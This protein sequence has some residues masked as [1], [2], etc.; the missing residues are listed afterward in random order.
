MKIL[1]QQR[2]LTLQL[3]KNGASLVGFGDVSVTKSEITDRFPVAVAL[4][5]KFDDTIV[6]NLHNDEAAFHKHQV[7]VRAF[8]E[9]L[10]GIATGML[11][12]WGYWYEIAP[13]KVINSNEELSRFQGFPYKTAATCAG[14]GWIGKSDLLVTPEHGPRVRLA[15][16]LTD[17]PFKTAEPVTE[18]RCGSCRLCVDACP[19]QA[20]KDA[21]WHRGV[22]REALLDPYVCNQKRLDYIPA[23]GRKYACG[24]CIQACP[25]GRGK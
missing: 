13:S 8:M 15:A 4:A 9:G 16:I 5:V 20:I 10:V 14:L 23:I 24:R 22:E 25:V 3:K 1:E 12:G 6:D 19:N 21:V 7:E 11:Q 2:E 18:G 17:A